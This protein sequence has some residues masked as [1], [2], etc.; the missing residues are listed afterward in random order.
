MISCRP[1]AARL[2]EE[3]SAAG[4]GE[5]F[6]L[7]LGAGLAYA[8]ARVGIHS[9]RPALWR[10]ACPRRVGWSRNAELELAGRRGRLQPFA[11]SRGDSCAFLVETG[12]QFCKGCTLFCIDHGLSCPRTPKP[13]QQ[14]CLYFVYVVPNSSLPLFLL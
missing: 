2:L 3:A 6:S 1:A 5:S 12:G 14:A 4:G 7:W 8:D 10:K 11:A 13:Y 9:V